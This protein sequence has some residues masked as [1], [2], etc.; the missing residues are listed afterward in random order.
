MNVQDS[1][2]RGMSRWFCTALS[3]DEG[4]YQGQPHWCLLLDASIFGRL[5]ISSGQKCTLE[6]VLAVH[7]TS[8]RVQGLGP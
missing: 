6:N 4:I 5:A 8:F 3:S 2:D 1:S 7:M